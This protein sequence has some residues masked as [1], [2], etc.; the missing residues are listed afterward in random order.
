MTD[1]DPAAQPAERKSNLLFRVA[2]WLL[3]FGCF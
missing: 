1:A 2:T 3:T